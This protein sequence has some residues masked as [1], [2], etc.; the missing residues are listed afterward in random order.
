MNGDI[1]LRVLFPCIAM[2]FSAYAFVIF[3]TSALNYWWSHHTKAATVSFL[4]FA[5]SVWALVVGLK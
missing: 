3:G 2:L 4:M 5:A 1:F